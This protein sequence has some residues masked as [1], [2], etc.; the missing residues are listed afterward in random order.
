[1]DQHAIDLVAQ[2]SGR[3]GNFAIN[4]TQIGAIE[5]GTIEQVAR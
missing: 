3:V 1:M 4:D 2:L 5:H